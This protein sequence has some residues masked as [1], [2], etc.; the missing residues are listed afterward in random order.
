MSYKDPGESQKQDDDFEIEI[1]GLAASP[2]E[3]ASKST[4]ESG[5]RSDLNETVQLTPVHV[6]L[7]AKLTRRQRIVRVSGSAI[8]IIVALLLI[9]NSIVPTH[10]LLGL[11]AGPTPIATATLASNIDHFYLDAGPPW[12]K[13]TL[14]GQPLTF[15]TL[16]PV[17]FTRGHH[18]FVWQASPFQPIRCTLSVPVATTDT[19]K[20]ITI[21]T[22]V[23]GAASTAEEVTFY[24]TL[25]MLPKTQQTA[26]IQAAQAALDSAQSTTTV[27]P[28]EQFVHVVGSH[29]TAIA[30]QPL[31]AILHFSLSVGDPELEN[32]ICA[33][34]YNSE[35][36]SLY[37]FK[38]QDVTQN[39]DWFCTDP[40][41]Y[42]TFTVPNYWQTLVIAY[43]Y[44]DF[45][46]LD[47]HTIATNQPDTTRDLTNSAHLLFLNFIWDGTRWQATFD[48]LQ[49]GSYNSL[50]CLAANNELN[51][52][53]PPVGLDSF[54]FSVTPATVP[55]NGCLAIIQSTA[56]SPSSS[57][58]VS[59]PQAFCLYRFGVLLAA[60]ALAHHYWPSMPVANPYEQSLAK[61]LA[62]T[63]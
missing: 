30:T 53:P 59:P 11:L 51:A 23:N 2:E 46:T 26:L 56:A 33:S 7:R 25:N 41:S 18:Q 27:Q 40:D 21:A 24:D 50:G 9:L 43:E 3:P 15:S 4:G 45:V 34:Y 22:Q 6:S 52:M 19:C 31:H 39:C 60:N 37:R 38:S 14:D 17:Q 8:V 58:E 29:T 47:G 1:I 13:L 28:G 20:H 36:S 42:T 48:A 61:R 16:E 5:E 10:R 32:A 49:G 55:A 44:W 12:G 35:C 63:Q 57:V 54:G 62:A